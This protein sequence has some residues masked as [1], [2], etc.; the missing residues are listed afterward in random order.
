[1]LLTTSISISSQNV[2]LVIEF[3]VKKVPYY[4]VQRTQPTFQSRYG[5]ELSTDRNFR[6]YFS[7]HR[8]L[9]N[10]NFPNMYI[11]K[12]LIINLVISECWAHVFV[13]V[14]DRIFPSMF[15]FIVELILNF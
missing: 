14:V 8:T 1:M 6:N 4:V 10:G 5:P 9:Q 12:L 3:C 11:S 2:L 13:M 15:K 7:T